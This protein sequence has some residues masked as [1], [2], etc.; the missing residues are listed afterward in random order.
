M[1]IFKRE[2]VYK[3]TAGNASL[4]K[5]QCFLI[6]CT[7]RVTTLSGTP[8][9]RDGKN[10]VAVKQE[11]TITQGIINQGD[12]SKKTNIKLRLCNKRYFNQ[13]GET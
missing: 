1:R 12:R 7:P 3:N 9:I 13:T 6:Y 11:V 2:T 8:K 5:N 4:D 10:S